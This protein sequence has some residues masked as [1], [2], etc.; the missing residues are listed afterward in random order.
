MNRSVLKFLGLAAM[1]LL[2]ALLV[3]DATTF[4]I[5]KA[6]PVKGRVRGCYTTLALL[7]G[8]KSPPKWDWTRAVELAGAGV[9]VASVVVLAGKPCRSE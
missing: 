2:A 9:L 4:A 5:A 8:A 7:L 6:D 1:C 3:M